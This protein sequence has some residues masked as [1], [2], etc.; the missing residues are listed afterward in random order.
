MPPSSESTPAA[1]PRDTSLA[2][3]RLSPQENT[4]LGLAVGV[5]D[6]SGTQW[7]V[8]C[9]NAAQQRLKLTLDP[10][11]LYRGY[12]AN[13]L[14]VGTKRALQVPIAASITNVITGGMARRLTDSEQL[15]CAASAGLLSA[16]VV[17]PIELVM[18]QQQKFG[19]SLLRTPLELV[20]AHGLSVLGRAI[21]VTCGRESVYTAGLLGL[22]P[23]I[24]RYSQESLGASNTTAGIMG[25]VG[26]G[27]L[28]A[29]ISHPLDT[30]KTCLQGDVKC[31]KYRGLAQTALELYSE[32]G[33]LR[34]FSGWGWRTGR[35]I[36]QVFLVD[37]CR[38]SLCPLMFPHHY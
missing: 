30:I 24:K 33:L 28:V 26:A 34:L 31:V 10:R 2:L 18:I 1:S 35:T 25:A 19:T 6:T 20:N 38:Q 8:Y 3:Q 4:L 29:T 36:L 17:S 9:K 13:L 23:V 15:G 12:A 37:K 16:L 27:F 14:N 21:T 22:G 32:G 11:I 7:M 5:V